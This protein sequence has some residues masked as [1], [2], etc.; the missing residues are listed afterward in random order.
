A[1]PI[2]AIVLVRGREFTLGEGALNCRRARFGKRTRHAGT[3]E[4]RLG[5]LRR[6]ALGGGF[7][8]RARRQRA[9]AGARGGR[10]ERSSS[11]GGGMDLDQA[12]ARDR[13]RGRARR[14]RRRGRRG[15]PGWLAG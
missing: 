6:G 1:L 3:L 5:A 14:G 7:E 13:G 12:I 15:R 2:V 8:S 11:S 9:G 4:I 10:A